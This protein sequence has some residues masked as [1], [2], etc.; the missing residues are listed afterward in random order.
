MDCLGVKKEVHRNAGLAWEETLWVDPPSPREKSTKKT[1]TNTLRNRSH[2]A[3]T[4]KYKSKIRPYLKKRSYARP[5]STLQ[6]INTQ[7]TRP[8]N[9]GPNTREKHELPLSVASK[10]SVKVRGTKGT[11]ISRKLVSTEWTSEEDAKELDRG[12]FEEAYKSILVENIAKEKSHDL[13]KIEHC[14]C[15]VGEGS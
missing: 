11:L 6:I 14:I 13:E 7:P 2:K 4:T 15:L 10:D 12:N 1:L 8:K 9:R 5:H 3:R